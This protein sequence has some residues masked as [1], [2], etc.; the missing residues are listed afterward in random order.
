[1]IL[2]IIIFIMLVVDPKYSTGIQAYLMPQPTP[3]SL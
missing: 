2:L 3:T 1:M